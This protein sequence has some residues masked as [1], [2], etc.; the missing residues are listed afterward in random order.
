MVIKGKFLWPTVINSTECLLG[1]IKT[2]PALI[3]WQNQ[4]I[5][6]FKSDPRFGKVAFVFKDGRMIGF[7][8]SR[9]GGDNW[10]KLSSDNPIFQKSTWGVAGNALTWAVRNV[11]VNA[12]AT[13]KFDGTIVLS[14][15]FKDAFDLSS[16]DGRSAAYNFISNATGFMYHDVTGG[17]SSLQVNANWETTI[18][19]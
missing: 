19:E 5:K 6:I 11:N 9:T 13:V 1:K 7:G 14:Y 15:G 16:Q 10:N 18:D 8:G 3:K 2:D 12:E 4:L 17:N